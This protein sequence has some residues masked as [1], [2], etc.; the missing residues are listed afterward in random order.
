MEYTAII[1]EI[2]LILIGLYIIFFKSYFQ[3]KGENLA[4]KEDISRITEN[5]EKVKNELLFNSQKK[6]ELFFETQKSLV[7]FYDHYI[8]WMDSN[9]R[10]IDVIINHSENSNFIRTSI[11]EL[12]SAQTE[13]SKFLSRIL[14]YVENE[15]FTTKIVD[16]HSKS[17]ELH[18]ITLS[19]LVKTEEYALSIERI[20]YNLDKQSLSVE[21]LE[22]YYEIKDSKKVKLQEQFD[23]FANEIADRKTILELL[24]QD[25]FKLIQSQLKKGYNS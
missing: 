11:N 12:K 18:N 17:S 3:K 19:F 8:Y 5:I 14:L 20:N 10:I 6:K 1:L 22:Q 4:T 21:L 23:K 7:S 16:V 13:V 24:Y 15:E 25:F 2:L 9:R